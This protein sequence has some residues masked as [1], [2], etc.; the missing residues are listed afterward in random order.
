MSFNERSEKKESE[1]KEDIIN[2]NLQEEEVYQLLIENMK[3][4]DINGIEQEET[5]SSQTPKEAI[6]SLFYEGMN[7]EY[8]K[9]E[10]YFNLTDWYIGYLIQLYKNGDK[11]IE[12]ELPVIISFSIQRISDVFKEESILGLLM[13][14]VDIELQVFKRFNE[15]IKIIEQ[16]V[17]IAGFNI[18]NWMKYIEVLRLK[19]DF[20]KSIHESNVEKNDIEREVIEKTRKIINRM[21]HVMKGADRESSM[22][23][24]DYGICF[25]QIHGNSISVEN[26]IKKRREVINIIENKEKKAQKQEEFTKK[27]KKYEKDIK[28]INDKTKKAT[29]VSEDKIRSVPRRGRIGFSLK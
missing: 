29:R 2:E 11:S 19:G 26:M 14:W 17:S 20:E 22:A 21:I 3:S 23:A 10:Y 13:K 5:I 16:V 28:R 4:I 8:S 15:G 6:Y 1:E 18:T 25:E 24:C 12:N 27:K 7:I 9:A